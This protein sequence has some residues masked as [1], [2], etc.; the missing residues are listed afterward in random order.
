MKWRHNVVKKTKQNG[1]DTSCYQN[2]IRIR[3]MAFTLFLRFL[4]NVFHNLLKVLIIYKTTIFR[5]YC[6][7]NLF[8]R[9]W[10]TPAFFST[11]HPIYP[12]IH[13][14]SI[15]LVVRPAESLL[16]N[17][18]PSFPHCATLARGNGNIGQKKGVTKK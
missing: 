6:M 16:F 7:K 13:I 14:A 1:D 18:H 9:N 11:P 2:H 12:I 4:C 10:I 3:S 5:Y 15:P 17:M 8:L